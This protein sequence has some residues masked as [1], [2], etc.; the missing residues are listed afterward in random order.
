MKCINCENSILDG[1]PHRDDKGLLDHYQCSCG[2]KTTTLMI[3]YYFKFEEFKELYDKTIVDKKFG[4][5]LEGGKP[6]V[7]FKKDRRDEL[8]M[9]ILGKEVG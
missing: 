7:R 1:I 9:V 5:V 2:N 8:A 3:D 4:I 6:Q